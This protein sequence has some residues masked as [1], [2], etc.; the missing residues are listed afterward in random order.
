MPY[1]VYYSIGT[2]TQN[3]ISRET[4]VFIL[5]RVEQHN[6]MRISNISNN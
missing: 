2:Y 5:I 3:V 4:I 6:A 1:N